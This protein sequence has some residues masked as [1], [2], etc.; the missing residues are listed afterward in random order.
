[1]WEIQAFTRKTTRKP[2]MMAIWFHETSR[3][4]IRGGEISAIYM[5]QRIEAHPTATPPRIRAKANCPRLEGI[6]DPTAE[7]EKKRAAASK[8]LLLPKRSLTGAAKGAPRMHP[9]SALAT[10]HPSW[11]GVRRKKFRR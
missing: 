11:A 7:R 4:R 2:E 10:A 1:M 8:A 5:G 9:T 6:A 3:P